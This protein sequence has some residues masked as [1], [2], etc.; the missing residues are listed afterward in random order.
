MTSTSGDLVSPEVTTSLIGGGQVLRLLPPSLVLVTLVHE[1]V[2][3]L[4]QDGAQ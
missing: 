4:V 2:L 3:G 1:L